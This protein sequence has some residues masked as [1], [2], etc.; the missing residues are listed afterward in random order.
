[1]WCFEWRYITHLRQSGH[2]GD[3]GYM[4]RNFYYPVK[5][6]DDQLVRR[7]ESSKQSTEVLLFGFAYQAIVQ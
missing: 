7:E 3:I 5:F 6:F 4:I 2:K 1:M